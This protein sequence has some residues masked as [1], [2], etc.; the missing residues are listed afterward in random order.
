MTRA[1]Q[2]AQTRQRLLDSTLGV[3]RQRGFAA[4]TIEEVTDLAGYTRGVFY[5]YFESKEEA[6]LEVLEQHADAQISSFRTAVTKARSEALAIGV[7]TSLLLPALGDEGARLPQ[8]N[9]LALALHRNEPLRLRALELQRRIEQMVGECALHLCERRGQRPSR[10]RAQL[11]AVICALA[12]GLATR[13][14][15]EPDFEP[16]KLFRSALS[17]LLGQ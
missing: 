3:V 1:E 12:D 10:D 7:M 9:E 8:N 11:G 17:E 16:E 5:A 6:W 2:Q 14:L 13:R 15:I 4:A